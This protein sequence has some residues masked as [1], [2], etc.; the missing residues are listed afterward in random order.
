MLVPWP[1]R[2]AGDYQF[3]GRTFD[4]AT[5]VNRADEEPF[6]VDS[7]GPEASRFAFDFCKRDGDVLP[8]DE[9]TAKFCG[10]QFVPVSQGEDGEWAASDESASRDKT[11]SDESFADVAQSAPFERTRSRKGDS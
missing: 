3:A 10:V 4:H 11:A 7:D 2:G 1:G 6:E 9:E 5:M 8:A